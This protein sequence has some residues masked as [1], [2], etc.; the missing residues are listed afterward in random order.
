[1]FRIELQHKEPMSSHVERLRKAAQENERR[2]N[3]Y[4]EAIHQ[5]GQTMYQGPACPSY[6]RTTQDFMANFIPPRTHDKRH[7]LHTARLTDGAVIAATTGNRTEDQLHVL[8]IPKIGDVSYLQDAIDCRTAGARILEISG[9]DEFM[10]HPEGLDYL[11]Y[12][13]GA[14]ALEAAYGWQN[15]YKNAPLGTN[16]DVSG[17]QL[18]VRTAILQQN[19]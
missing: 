5:I 3:A 15:A 2:S 18:S 8:T 14:L 17:Q 4:E 1:M 13:A 19:K 9:K 11:H 12:F 16:T 7:P 6:G 10:T